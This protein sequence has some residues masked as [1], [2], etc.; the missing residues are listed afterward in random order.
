MTFAMR[1]GL[2]GAL[3]VAAVGLADHLLAWPFLTAAIGPTAYAFI[4]HPGSRSSR[5]RTAAF[6]HCTGITAG[7]AA[8]AAFGLWSAPSITQTGRATVAQALATATASAVTLVIL[9]LFDAHHSPAAAS[10][11]LVATGLARPVRPVEGLAIGLAAVILAAS[12]LV[13]IL[14]PGGPEHEQP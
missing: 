8:L 4:A 2:L 6:G 3:I 10:A 1:L 9:H 13:A 11:I 7:L 5:M 12:L 14:P